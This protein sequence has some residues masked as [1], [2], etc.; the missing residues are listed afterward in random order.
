MPILRPVTS[1][2]SHA[3]S[4]ADAVLV[5]LTREADHVDQRFRSLWLSY[6]E[7]HR[8]HFLKIVSL[9]PNN[10]SGRNVVDVGCFPGIM[11]IL[12]KRVGWDV[13]G[14]DL[15]PGRLAGFWEANAIPVHA[16]DIEREA[17]PLPDGSMDVVLLTE[18]LE[19][20]RLNPI[21]SLRECNR[22]ARDGGILLLSVPNVSPRHR[23]RFL[24]GRDYQGDIIK[25]FAELE[26]TGSMGHFRLYSQNEVRQLVQHVGF[27]ILRA[28]VAGRLP[29]GRWRFV[30]FLPGR[31]RWR[32]HYY[33][34][35]TKDRA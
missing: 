2:A 30:R 15:D 12:L 26:K 27:T 9:L 31:D 24:F 18:V 21:L 11:A 19:H 20:L 23:I 4:S 29:G 35:A 25:E 3:T 5:S 33:V 22:V 7:S 16:V 6:L 34:V 13:V 32:S 10:A 1:S 14:M 8:A 28:E 17:L